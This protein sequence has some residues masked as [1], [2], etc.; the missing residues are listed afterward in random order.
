V[1]DLRRVD[2]IWFYLRILF[3][4]DDEYMLDAA[5]PF[6]AQAVKKN[7]FLTLLA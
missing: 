7:S 3:P 4:D 2:G 1:K 5:K 6:E